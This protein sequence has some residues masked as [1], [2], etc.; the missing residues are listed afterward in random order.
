MKGEHGPCFWPA[1]LLGVC[2]PNVLY[3]TGTVTDFLPLAGISIV[4]GM[5]FGAIAAVVD[6]WLE[7]RGLW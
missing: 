4:G 1:M 6:I 5:I 2:L 7:E 3:F